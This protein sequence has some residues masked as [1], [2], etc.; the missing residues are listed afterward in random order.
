VFHLS[1]PVGGD[2]YT[3]NAM[4]VGLGEA[5]ARRYRTTHGPSLRA[6]YDVAD[7]SRSRV[8][9]SSGQSGLPWPAATGPSCSPGPKGAT[10][11][12]GPAGPDTRRGGTLLLKPAADLSRTGR[13][14]GTLSGF[15]RAALPVFQ[16]F[17]RLVDPYPATPPA[18]L[19]RHFWPFIWACSEGM[20]P[21]SR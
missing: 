12:C 3:V 14:T 10:S 7:R 8:M 15:S 9:H 2:T 6:L 11:R 18:R 4:R 20:R 17:E 1:V 19:P 16:R 5:D 13:N 21:R